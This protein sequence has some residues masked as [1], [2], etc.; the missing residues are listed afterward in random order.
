MDLGWMESLIYDKCVCVALERIYRIGE[1]VTILHS[2]LNTNT[3][4]NKI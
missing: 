4:I 3:H 2:S 1:C